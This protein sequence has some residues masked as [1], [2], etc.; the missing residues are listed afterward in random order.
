MVNNND[1]CYMNRTAAAFQ[2]QDRYKI[3][4]KTG[5]QVSL[6]YWTSILIFS[7]WSSILVS[8]P[9]K[10]HSGQSINLGGSNHLSYFYVFIDLVCH[11]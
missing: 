1:N 9:E 2:L 10:P 6:R 8:H 7:R 11:K 4:R 3:E 5:G